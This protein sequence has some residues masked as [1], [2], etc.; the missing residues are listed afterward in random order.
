M[1]NINDIVLE[2]LQPI[3]G[4]LNLFLV[5]VKINERTEAVRVF[6][7]K[8]DG[9]TIDDCVA[10]SRAL[11]KSLNEA[12]N[13]SEKY[14]LEVSSPGADQPFKVHEQYVQY[15]NRPVEVIVFNGMKYTGNLKQVSDSGIVITTE[16]KEKKN[17]LHEDINLIFQ[18]IKSTK[19]FLKY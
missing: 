17:I 10:V 6:I 19:P 15:L 11:E 3:L 7:D 8:M 16:K 18:D 1:N 14:A 4:Q 2:H 5:E 9:I 13:F 12:F